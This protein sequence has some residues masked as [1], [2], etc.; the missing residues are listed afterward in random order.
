MQASFDPLMQYSLVQKF[1]AALEQTY[2]ADSIGESDYISPSCFMYLVERLLI[3]VFYLKG[4]FFTIKSSFLEWLI[5]QE[6]Y[7]NAVLGFE[8]EWQQ[9]F[10]S[11]LDIMAAIMAELLYNEHDVITWI[12][13][14]K[15]SLAFHSQLVLRLFVA[16][17]LI[18]VNSGNYYELLFELINTSDI[19]CHL[20]QEFFDVIQNLKPGNVDDNVGVLAEA[21]QKIGNPLV[22]VNS[23]GQCCT[24]GSEVQDAIFIDLEVHQG[25]E[26]L[27]SVSCEFLE[28][29]R[30]RHVA[31][32][33]Y[34]VAILM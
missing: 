14:F 12:K 26:E 16:L 19:T 18:C 28:P 3:L 2:Y 17:C 10:I 32:S 34:D 33:E 11:T 7:K 30:L 9:N 31:H 13:N 22:V 5:N 15:H 8:D 4:C 6:W 23:S 1:H 20:P 29:S 21:F 27:H 24:T 25:R